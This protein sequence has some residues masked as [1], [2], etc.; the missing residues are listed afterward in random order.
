M[1]LSNYERRELDQIEK[2]LCAEDPRLAKT[3][4]SGGVP[5]V[6]GFLGL[7]AATAYAV[8]CLPS[9]GSSR[10]PG[11]SGRWPAGLD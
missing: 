7:F 10:R 5:V 1:Q 8:C 9:M 3:V 11:R 4:E 6:T 2:S